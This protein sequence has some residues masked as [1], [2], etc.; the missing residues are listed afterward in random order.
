MVESGPA[1]GVIAAANIGADA[2]FKNVI[3][4]D[5]GGT[6]AKVGV[7]ENGTPQL[8]KDFEVGATAAAGVGDRR[9]SGYPIR[10]PVLD[11]VEIGAG[12]GSIA[13][14]DSGG[15]LRVGPRSAGADPGPACYGRGGT[16]PTVTDANLVLGRLDA[17]HFLGGE[18][19][20]DE[21]AAAR[22]IMNRCASPLG[23]DLITA[24]YSIVE[25]ANVAMGNALRLVTVQRG[26]DPR[27]FALVAFGG[28]GPV[29]ANRIAAANNVRTTIIPASP[30]VASAAGLLG[31]DLKQEYA[32][33]IMTRTDRVDL[34]HVEE[35]FAALERQGAA[36]LEAQ[37]VPP[38][39]R[40]SLRQVEMRYAG[41]SYELT[42]D[43]PKSFTS[44]TLDELM[45]TFHDEHD[46]AFGF[47]APSEVIE[48]V[49]IRVI[50]VGTIER[51]DMRRNVRLLATDENPQKATRPVVFDPVE[52]ALHCP[53]FDRYRLAPGAEIAGPAI[54]E[55][56]DSST[57]I[58]PG[59]C[60][61]VND[62][63]HLV[64]E[65]SETSS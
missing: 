47:S 12:G 45:Q 34:N 35:A 40:K 32:Q 39:E 61:R 65:P 15:M 49:T 22:A 43:A 23:M 56:V 29:H 4:F 11:L 14:V 48:L 41:Q 8:T 20:L 18:L 13:W 17:K 9:G 33:V 37:G 26:H 10:A 21:E 24:A 57:L 2:G 58:H 38:S 51:P 55:E 6:T 63:G 7:I 62:Y 53:I 60:A 64:I 16:E 52:G 46:R 30:G 25:I 27:E 28:A 42:L 3:S 31:T 50:G 5:M 36:D 54:V 19:V 1:A 59:Y 44:E